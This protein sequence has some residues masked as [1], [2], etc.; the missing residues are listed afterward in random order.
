MW[1]LFFVAI[2][3]IIPLNLYFLTGSLVFLT[4][5]DTNIAAFF[6][7]KKLCLDKN[8]EEQI[9]MNLKKLSALKIPRFSI[10]LF[11]FVLMCTVIIAQILIRQEEK[12]QLRDLLDRG[13]YLI[14]LISLHP[15]NDFQGDKRDFFLRT[16]T[17][18]TTYQGLVY[19]YIHDAGKLP[20]VSLTP[21]NIASE[22]PHDIQM[23]SLNAMGLKK[24]PF[25][26]GKSKI[27]VYEFAKP[28]FEQGKKTGTV[29]LGLKPPSTSPFSFERIRLLVMIALFVIAITLFLY[30]GITVSL[31]PLKKLNQEFKT[32]CGASQA[33][34]CDS[35]DGESI[36][37]TI[38]ALEHSLLIIKE[39][40]TKIETDNVALASKL[41]VTT[42]EKNQV[43]NILDSINFGIVITDIQDTVS[44]MNKYLLRLLQRKQEDVRDHPLADILKHDEILSFISELES[45]QQNNN[46]RQLE[47]TFP[48]LAPGDIFSVSLIVLKDGQGRFIGKMI[49][50][51]KITREKAVEEAQREFITHIA[52]E[53]KTPLTSIKSYSEMLM[54]GDIDDAEM[55]KEFYN[56]IN[57]EADRLT[58][59]IQNTLSI[60]RIEMGSLALNKG[61]VKTDWLAE[62]SIAAVETAAQKKHIILD[63]NFPEVFP[64]LVGDKELLKVAI[65]NLL[66][67]AVKYTP[68]N[69][70]ITFSLTDLNDVVVFDVIDTGVGISDDDLPH[71]FE[72]SFRSS[73]PKIRDESGSGLGLAIASEIIHLHGGDIE[74]E[75]EPGEG[76]H[77][78]IRFPKEDYYIGKQ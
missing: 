75:S 41:G 64:T 3:G 76:T 36:G 14:S 28:I 59:L 65:I 5:A 69:G 15:L 11:I 57:A 13:N 54:D 55:K 6:E 51:R 70:K 60:S 66:S 43:V 73:D 48:E 17:E 61:L 10:F 42:F 27:T 50:V 74:V 31:R 53:L 45:G 23:A 71:I 4:I 47:T 63:K 29:R 39:K 49:S 18:N 7:Q 52:H 35:P 32:T 72:R 58:A 38:K 1:R 40:L 56:T 2:I 77:F 24:Q 21:D 26:A 8:I 19:F 67:N 37:L 34:V 68:E 20:I 25:T 62:D 78:L 33:M 22:I 30:Y 12:Y 44:L 9:L 46:A 16:L